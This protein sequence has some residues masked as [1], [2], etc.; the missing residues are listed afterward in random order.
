MSIFSS[1][2]ARRFFRWI[3]IRL[4]RVQ[5]P[6]TCYWSPA[7]ANWGFLRPNCQWNIRAPILMF[8]FKHIGRPRENIKK[9]K[10]N[11]T[12]QM[13]WSFLSSRQAL[14]M[15]FV[16]WA[17]IFS[18]IPLL[19]AKGGKWFVKVVFRMIRF[20]WFDVFQRFPLFAALH[21]LGND[22]LTF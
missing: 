9:K 17:S 22:L 5:G 16:C 18:F 19:F 13:W 6:L 15:T 10:W 8:Y 4:D 20:H 3:L 7:I 12:C 2:Q 14:K 11:K 1:R 21:H